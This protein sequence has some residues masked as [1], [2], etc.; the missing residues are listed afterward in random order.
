MAK[1]GHPLPDG[2]VVELEC[3]LRAQYAR[4]LDRATMVCYPEV[5]VDEGSG[6]GCVAVLYTSLKLP[7]LRSSQTNFVGKNNDFVQ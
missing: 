4:G 5:P 6:H 2:V 7:V 1:S 3:R